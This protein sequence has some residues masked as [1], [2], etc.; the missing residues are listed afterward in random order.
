MSY[1]NRE[2]RLLLLHGLMDENVHFSHTVTL[3]K[4]LVDAGKPYDLQVFPVEGHLLKSPQS[5]EN[6]MTYVLSYLQL[7]L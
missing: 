3:I 1:I 7:N 4:A 2:N 5:F 6:Y